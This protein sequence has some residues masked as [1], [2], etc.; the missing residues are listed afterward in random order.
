MHKIGQETS[1]QI[2]YR[3]ASLVRVETARIKYACACEEGGVVV[4]SLSDGAQVIEKG[5]A[6]PGLLAHV[7]VEKYADHLPVN[8]IEERFA[9]E[10]VHLA[11]S[12]LC[13]WVAQ[14]ADLPARFPMRWRR[15]C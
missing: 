6:G 2:D 13:D 10:G 12:T 7:M 1:T 3:P 8:R 15:R 4:P 9:R 14:V 11:K 5:L